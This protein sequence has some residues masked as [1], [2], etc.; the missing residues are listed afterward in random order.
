MKSE[1]GLP[2][3]G[4]LEMAD[5]PAPKK[6]VVVRE[7]G[8]VVKAFPAQRTPEQEKELTKMKSDKKFVFV[9]EWFKSEE[10]LKQAY[11]LNE[12]KGGLLSFLGL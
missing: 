7:S 2:V 11:N 5:N 10:E 6:F 1:N 3:D 12:G 8:K 9:S 4:R